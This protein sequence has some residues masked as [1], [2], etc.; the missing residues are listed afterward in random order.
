MLYAGQVFWE[1]GGI[2]LDKIST[3]R[4]QDTVDV[5]IDKIKV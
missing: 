5:I 1:F 2:L 3:V 4:C